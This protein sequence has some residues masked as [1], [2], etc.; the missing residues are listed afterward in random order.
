MSELARG[1]KVAKELSNMLN[2]GGSK[3]KEDFIAFM[4]VE[5]RFLQNE[6]NHLVLMWLKQ[7]NEYYKNGWYDARN[8][9]TTK[10]LSDLYEVLNILNRK[11]G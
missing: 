4:R 2:S 3:E 10:I 6:F 5:H 11:G 1:K 9:Y 7:C 8:E